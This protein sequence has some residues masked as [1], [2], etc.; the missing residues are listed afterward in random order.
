[1]CDDAFATASKACLYSSG[2]S[3]DVATFYSFRTDTCGSSVA[4]FSYAAAHSSTAAAAATAT[5]VSTST[6]SSSTD[7]GLSNA[8]SGGIGAAATVAV[9][10]A[11]VAALYAAGMV[12]FGRKRNDVSL[13][14]ASV[15]SSEYPI[16]PSHRQVHVSRAQSLLAVYLDPACRLTSALSV[17]PQHA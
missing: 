11:L 10:G 1:M 7:G 14:S 6:T 8:A 13:D 17:R 5:S 9:F 15:T 12:R 16:K 3:S 4:T 2:C